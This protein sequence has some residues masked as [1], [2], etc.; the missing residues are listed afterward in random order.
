MFVVR[1]Y[2]KSLLLRLDYFGAIFATA[3]LSGL[4]LLICDVWTILEAISTIFFRYLACAIFG[5]F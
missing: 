1:L 5:Q 2:Q 4:F 3:A